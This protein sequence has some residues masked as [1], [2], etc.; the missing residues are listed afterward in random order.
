MKR[1]KVFAFVLAVCAA[2]SVATYGCGED[3]GV[4]PVGVTFTGAG[5]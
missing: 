5:S 3:G 2:V 1:I 4:A